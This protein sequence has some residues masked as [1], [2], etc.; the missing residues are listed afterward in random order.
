MV[1]PKKPTL[2]P[3]A[4]EFFKAAGKRGGKKRFEGMSKK[5]RVEFARKGVE[6]RLAKKSKSSQ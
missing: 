6:A 2:S 4:K 5:D 1:R 3:E